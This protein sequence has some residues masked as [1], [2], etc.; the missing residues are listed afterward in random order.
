MAIEMVQVVIAQIGAEDFT[1]QLWLFVRGGRGGAS[2]GWVSGGCHQ[3]HGQ[4]MIGDDQTGWTR[5]GLG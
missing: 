2:A 5:C 1:G 4:R 3:L